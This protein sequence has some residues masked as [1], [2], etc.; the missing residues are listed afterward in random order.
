[1]NRT[2]ETWTMNHAV[3]E[4]V[5][6]IQE[7]K[8]TVAVQKVEIEN[9]ISELLALHDKIHELESNIYGGSTK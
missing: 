1:M 9:L 2:Y 6:Q 8:T 7:L 5:G 4:Y 3:E